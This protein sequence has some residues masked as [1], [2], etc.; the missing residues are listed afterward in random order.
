M[1]LIQIKLK[2]PYFIEYLESKEVPIL[3]AF[4]Y[5]VWKG[6]SHEMNFENL[7]IYMIREEFKRIELNKTINYVP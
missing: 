4:T 5:Y 6:S 7:S 1:V 3:S 2:I